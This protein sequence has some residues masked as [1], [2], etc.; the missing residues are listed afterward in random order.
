ML[1]V[2][3]GECAVEFR[4]RIVELTKGDMIVI[5]RGIEH[6]ALTT[7]ETAL[8]IFEPCGTLNTGDINGNLTGEILERIKN[9]VMRFCLIFLLALASFHVLYAQK[10]PI[11]TS[12][13]RI[14]PSVREPAISDDGDYATFYV[15]NDPTG[16]QSLLIHGIH[17]T[18]K[19]KIPGA[20]NAKITAD[21]RRVIFLKGKDSLGIIS[22]PGDSIQ[23]IPRVSSFKL[24][25]DGAE[26]YLAYLVNY[27]ESELILRNV[28]TSEERHFKAV[29]SYMFSGNGKVLLLESTSN[30]HGMGQESV[31]WVNLPNFTRSLIFEG[32]QP[33]SFIFDRT[34]SKLCFVAKDSAGYNS[35]WYYQSQ[36]N[37]LKCIVGD[38]SA[39]ADSSLSIDFISQFNEEGNAVY[40]YFRRK[41][42][43]GLSEHKALG[44]DVWSYADAR[45]QSRQLYDL[46]QTNSSN[47][48][49]SQYVSV[50]HLTD[51]K[52]VR[53][54]YDKDRTA[55]LYLPNLDRGNFALVATNE[56]GDFD[57]LSWNKKSECSFFLVS[58]LT[59]EKKEIRG[60]SNDLRAFEL[61]LEGK[62]LIYYDIKRNDWFSYD[63]EANIYRNI[64]KGIKAGR[65]EGSD[66]PVAHYNI[67]KPFQIAGH[68]K[69]D[70]D[71]LMYTGRDIS[72]IS[73]NGSHPP[74]NL[75][76]G[77]GQKHN[78]EF[79]FASN[80]QFSAFEP[81]ERVILSA[82]DKNT[83]QNGF[84]S[85][86]IGKS[87][88]PELLTMQPNM[89]EGSSEC[90]Q[91][92]LGR[93]IKAKNAAVYILRRMNSSESPNYFWTSDFKA[94]NPIT[95]LYPEKAY[96][97]LKTDLVTW[98]TF[99]GD[100]A[101]GILY[102][103]ENFDSRKK[104]PIIFFYYERMSDG[105]H[106]FLAPQFSPG[107]LNIPEYVSNGYLVFTP[108]IHFEP[109]NPGE[110]AY[111]SVVSAAK[112][113]SKFSWIDSSR[114]GI[115]GHSF[116]GYET[117]Y[118]VTH[119]AIFAAA[120]AGEGM[121]DLVSGSESQDEFGDSYQDFFAMEQ[122]RMNYTLW[123][124][125]DLYLR[126]SPIL[127]AGKV[128]TPLLIM[129]DKE[130]F[131]VP[132]MQGFEMFTAL[133]RLG[134]RT[135]M[136]QYDGRGHSLHDKSSED[137]TIR[138]RQFFDH[139]LKCEPAPRWM[140]EGIPA[141]HKGI[142][143]GL[144]L[145]RPGVE[146]GPGLLT[147]EEQKRVD[148]LHHRKPIEIIIK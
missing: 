9:I 55:F 87:T 30:K 112:Y 79:R 10:Q 5:P 128:T 148:S 53:L 109:G 40:F 1:S 124:R 16:S 7:V 133:R 49:F 68:I 136:L 106:L 66:M 122:Y 74:I 76:Y 129:D 48:Q 65:P 125:P 11:D 138:M 84:Y 111:N 97:W 37:E 71:I 69:G 31:E 82:F 4:D 29:K 81:A 61:S 144:E 134:K 126:N 117:Y 8:I 32:P 62:Y 19:L 101:Q 60:A 96:N 70:T 80:A 34:C 58:T 72:E 131:V 88:V 118:I 116:G 104:Y 36:M 114:M 123:E 108:D 139:Y 59:G 132:F 43:R 38:N 89:F 78:I 121:T 103:P 95:D 33:T 22:I 120:E 130:D 100:Y 21:S 145:E 26:Q 6:R 99:N 93:P 83:K 35:I 39:G 57:E 143:K 20:F 85:I 42:E 27:P 50:V 140:V 94:F 105:L 102:K 127:F 25:T 110:S 15:N 56:G 52:I 2:L 135:W 75:T 91:F 45:L 141:V 67:D 51:H 86:S 63:T 119:S 137:F 147:T 46:E 146:P 28:R 113:L 115:E 107:D 3:E 12:A 44:V 64:T 77:Y 73:L 23:Y 90:N 47:T 98:R 18:W 14:W 24:T 92:S 41:H 13:F 17:N 54:V 142:F